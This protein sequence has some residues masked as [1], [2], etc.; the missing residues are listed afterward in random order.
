[1]SANGHLRLGNRLCEA[2]IS[3][4][5]HGMQ[6][7]IVLAIV[8]QTIGWQRQAVSLSLADLATLC[9]CSPVGGFRRAIKE[10]VAEG[11]LHLVTE[12]GGAT[13][14]AYAVELDYERW[15]KFSQ[16]TRK[17]ESLWGR[18]DHEDQLPLQILTMTPGG[19]APVP[20]RMVVVD[21]RGSSQPVSTAAASASSSGGKTLKDNEKPHQPLLGRGDAMQLLAQIEALKERAGPSDPKQIIRR[22]RIRRELGEDVDTALRLMGGVD[23]VLKTRPEHRGILIG[24]LLVAVNRVRSQVAQAVNA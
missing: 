18:P 10:L 13:A 14:N 3:A 6:Y 24:D 23:R 20:S 11:V 15:G 22:D 21:P 17:L 7:K 16:A 4:P 8:R 19:N 12:G 2:L 9:G 5:F 1:M